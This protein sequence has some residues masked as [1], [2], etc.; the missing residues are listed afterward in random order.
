MLNKN[1]K[2]VIFLI[3]F[4][5]GFSFLIYEVSWNRYL[6]FILGTTVTASTIVLTAFMAGFGLGA[7]ILSKFAN[8]TSPFKI[9]IIVFRFNQPG[10]LAAFF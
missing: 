6:S 2:S 7:L 9:N 1:N 8:N 3:I 4:F 10:Q 5:A